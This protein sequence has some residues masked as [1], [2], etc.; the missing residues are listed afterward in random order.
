MR[1]LTAV[2]LVATV[3]FTGATACKRKRQARTE[4]VEDRG[5]LTSMIAV[6]DPRAAAQLI[7]GFHKV[8]DGAWRWTEGKFAVTLRTPA[9]AARK[10]AW[11]QLDFAIPQVSIDRLKSQ[12]LSAVVNAYATAPETYTKAGSYTYKR[13]IP[14][15]AMVGDAVT[16]EFTVDKALPPSAADWRELGVIV[17]SVGFRPK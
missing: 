11:L 5:S 15:S 17:T 7:R 13:E 9:G 1:R 6:A 2:L 3:A 8:E 16:A 12:T 14:A 4:V 10:G